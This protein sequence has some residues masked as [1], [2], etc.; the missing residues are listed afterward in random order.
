MRS[1]KIFIAALLPACLVS[2][3]GSGAPERV[4]ADS[5]VTSASIGSIKIPDAV[6]TDTTSAA[7]HA[8]ADTAAPKKADTAKVALHPVVTKK[9][10][11][12][13]V[14]PKKPVKKPIVPP[15]KAKKKEE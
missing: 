5:S 15:H 7:P 8:L 13:K 14:I 2:A 10:V 11:Q 12:P 6:N 1:A 4:K 3:C 9:P